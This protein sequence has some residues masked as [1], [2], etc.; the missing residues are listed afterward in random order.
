MVLKEFRS[1][2]IGKVS[3]VHFFWGS[4]DLAVTRFSGRRAPERPGADPITKEAYSHEVISHGFWP[5][6]GEIVKDAAFYA[7]AA[8]EPAGFKYRKVLPAKAFYSG[9]K[10]EFFLMYDDVRLAESPEQTLL[11]FCQSTYEAGASSGDWDRANLER[12]AVSATGA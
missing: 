12:P 4:F 6:D 7:Y 9:E 1:R 3:P 5:G 8:P 2:F 11:D 10:N